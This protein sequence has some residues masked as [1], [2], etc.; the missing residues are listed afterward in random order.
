MSKDKKIKIEIF[1]Y[2]SKR[3]RVYVPQTHRFM[4]RHLSVSR[5]DYTEYQKTLQIVAKVVEEMGFEDK[6]SFNI[7]HFLL[8]YPR[9]LIKRAYRSP[10]VIIDGEV[11]ASGA[12]PAKRKIKEVLT[13]MDIRHQFLEKK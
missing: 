12:V 1:T 4:Y 6:V 11:V 7:R 13:K 9:V 2:F 5:D 3:V 8:W 10:V